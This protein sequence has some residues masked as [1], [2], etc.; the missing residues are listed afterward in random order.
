MVCHDC[1]IF[2]LKQNSTPNKLFQFLHDFLQSKKQKVKL[3][4]QVYSGKAD[5]EAYLGLLLLP[6]YRNNLSD[7]KLSHY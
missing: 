5:G 6:I 4:G 3:N 7:G 1:I 2:I